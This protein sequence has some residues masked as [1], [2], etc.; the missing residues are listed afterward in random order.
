MGVSGFKRQAG[1]VD[2]PVLLNV[3]KLGVLIAINKF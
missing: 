3:D 1:F 2:Y